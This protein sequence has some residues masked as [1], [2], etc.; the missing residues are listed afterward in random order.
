M[1]HASEQ[2]IA[3]L[4]PLLEKVRLLPG[5]K[6]K[7]LGIFYRKSRA[8]LHFHEENS[9]VYADVRLQEPDFQRFPVTTPEDQSTFLSAVENFLL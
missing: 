3:G 2:T 7:K 5:L 1:K 6:E 4:A 8:F 9:D